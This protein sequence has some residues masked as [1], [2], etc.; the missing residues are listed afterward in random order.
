MDR[1]EIP[2]DTRQ[3]GVPSGASILISKPMVRSMQTV[4]LSC[5][6]VSTISKVTKLSFHLS[7]DIGVPLVHLA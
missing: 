7:L 6:K 4:H 3:L 2:Y 1:N 5:I